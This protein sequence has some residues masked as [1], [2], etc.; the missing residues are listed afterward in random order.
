M[1]SEKSVKRRDRDAAVPGRRVRKQIEVRVCEEAELQERL[2]YVKG[3]LRELKPELVVR[4]LVKDAAGP[5]SKGSGVY[6]KELKV[7]MS[8][9]GGI[10]AKE[11]E[12]RRFLN[13]AKR[14][15]G[16]EGDEGWW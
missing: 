5:P 2:K 15:R 12:T 16:G 8:L 1:G 4:L 6:S 3:R 7:L 13:M 9:V 14:R 11:G 10:P